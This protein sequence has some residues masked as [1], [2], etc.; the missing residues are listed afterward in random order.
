M[1]GLTSV[2]PL[3]VPCH[4][5]FDIS[6]QGTE[7]AWPHESHEDVPRPEA[8]SVQKREH[9]QWPM[10]IRTHERRCS[11]AVPCVYILALI[12]DDFGIWVR[13][14]Q[15]CGEYGPSCVCDSN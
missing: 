14:D 12:E 10:P 3:P 9:K 4:A 15:L 2:N 5:C 11:T 6:I 8:L 7:Q 13:A 1:S